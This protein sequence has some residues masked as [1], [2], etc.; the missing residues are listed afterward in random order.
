M[1]GEPVFL[2]ALES[3]DLDKVHQWHNDPSLYGC[4]VG[5]FRH[6]S[7]E[8]VESWLRQRQQFSNEEV[9]L[10]ICAKKGRQHIGN[11]YL[12]DIDWIARRAEL[13]VFIGE[14]AERSKGYG[15]AAV[16]LLLEHAFRGLGFQ[17]LYL[18]VLEDNLAAIRVYEKCGFAIEG[19]LIR[20]SF[21]NGQFKN[22]LAMGVCANDE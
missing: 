3:A 15:Q 11:I 6:V 14:A 21:K 16:R 5:T 17:R 18:Y 10:A 9:N 13:H 2:R 7:R 1:S 22:V 4:L 19:K 20:H 12:R 8:S